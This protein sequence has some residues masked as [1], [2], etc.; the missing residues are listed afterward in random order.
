MELA[1]E[2]ALLI[3]LGA[4]ESIG[5]QW[6]RIGPSR[7]RRVRNLT[8]AIVNHA[9]LPPFSVIIAHLLSHQSGFHPLAGLPSWIALTTAICTYDLFGYFLHRM[10]HRFEIL[11]RYHQVHHM[12]NDVDFTTGVRVHLIEACVQQVALV[13]IT[14]ALGVPDVYLTVF[15]ILLFFTSVFHHTNVAIPNRI[16]R[17][18]SPVINTPAVHV[19]H[20]HE[21]PRNNN[22]NFGNV[23]SFWDRIFGTFNRVRRDESWR[24][25]VEYS[26]DLSALGLSALPFRRRQPWNQTENSS[27]STSCI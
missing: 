16:E 27:E 18:L 21:K 25:G 11:W 3:G 5:T 4:I 17:V 20:H 24:L 12:D 7:S 8:L 15:L 9:A 19:V 10:N 2:V 13:L 1:I 26:D 14:L 22:T 6:N 23:F